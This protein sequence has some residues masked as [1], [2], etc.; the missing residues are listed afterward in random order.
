MVVIAGSTSSVLQRFRSWWNFRRAVINASR[1]DLTHAAGEM[2]VVVLPCWRRP[3][4]LWH[5]LHNLTRAAG[6]GSVHVVFRR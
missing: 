3:Q 1:V 5:C 2:D 6:I 4:F